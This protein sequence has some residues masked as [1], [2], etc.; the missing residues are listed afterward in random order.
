MSD[1]FYDTGSTP[2]ATYLNWK[3][4]HGLLRVETVGACYIFPLDAWLE[5]GLGYYANP[6]R[7]E[8]EHRSICQGREVYLDL[9]ARFWRPDRTDAVYP[10]SKLV[11]IAAGDILRRIHLK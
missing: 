9:D 3:K 10:Y 5:N 6:V 8:V 1:Y 2:E 7:F 11:R 4:S